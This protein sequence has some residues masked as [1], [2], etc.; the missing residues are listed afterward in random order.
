MDSNNNNNEAASTASSNK[1]RVAAISSTILSLLVF[2]VLIMPDNTAAFV[3]ELQHLIAV[4]FGWFYMLSVTGFLVLLIYC[5]LSKVGR[6]RLGKD[7]EQPEFSTFSWAA[8]LFS[9]GM[10]IGLVFFGV[11]E[12]VMHYLAPPIV[13]A[14]STQAMEGAMTITFFHWGFNAWAIYATVA[15]VISYA[16]YRKNLPVEM[17]SAL[18]P[19]IGKKIYGPIGDFVDVFAVLATVIGI[20]TPLGFGVMQIN[21]GLNYLFDVPKGITTQI[22]LIFAIGIVTCLSLLLGLKKGIKTLSV[23]N[24]NIAIGLMIFVLLAGNTSTVLNATVTSVGAYLSNIVP[25]TFDTYSQTNPGWFEGWTLFYWAWWI[26][27][28][29]PTGVFIA[30]ISRGRTIR[31]FVLGVLIIPV[32]FSFVWLSVFGITALDMIHNQGIT[33]L[34]TAVSADSS[35][36]LFKFFELFSGGKIISYLALFSIFV[37]FITTADSGTLVINIL[38]SEY[39]D[40]APAWQRIFWVVAVSTITALLL[41]VGGMGAIQAVLIILGFP[42]AIIISIMCIGLIKALLAESALGNTAKEKEVTVP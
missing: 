12:P 33:E 28:A 31:E 23:I 29:A 30:R 35:T 27:F 1:L 42:F 13:E 32:A 38:T 21:A 11:A 20:V 9:T 5:G 15:L 19:L 22:I 34:A 10:G 16:A 2:F 39:G 8:M 41:L 7:D 3:K 40:Q 17:R 25:L 18:Y 6:L 26:A 14:N 4:K 24:I 36:A 37:F